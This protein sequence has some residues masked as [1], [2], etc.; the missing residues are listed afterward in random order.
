MRIRMP[1]RPRLSQRAPSRHGLARLMSRAE[2]AVGSGSTS[3]LSAEAVVRL[4]SPATGNTLGAVTARDS[5][6]RLGSIP[7]TPWGKTLD[8]AQVAL[9]AGM[10]PQG[11]SALWIR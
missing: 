9:D 5:S 10:G 4:R 1:N 3:A 6:A 11:S 8:S 2:K 7:A